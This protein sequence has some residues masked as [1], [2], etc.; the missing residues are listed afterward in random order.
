MDLYERN[1]L[2][3]AGTNR[4]LAHLF[5]DRTVPYALV[6]EVLGLDGSPSD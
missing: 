2:A 5:A 4:T 3:S 6:D 1:Y